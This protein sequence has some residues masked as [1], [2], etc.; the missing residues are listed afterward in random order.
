VGPLLASGLLLAGLGLR[1]VFL[2]AALPAAVCMLV[3]V[4]TVREAPRR[5]VEVAV[6]D[7]PR[8]P[9]GDSFG[10]YLAL[11]ALFTLGNSSDAFLLLRAQERGV[12][13]AA[14]PLLWSFHHVVKAAT[15]TWAGTLSDRIGRR[16]TIVAG[17]G[18]YAAAYAGFAFAPGPAAP[19]LL[20]AVYA[21]HHAATEGPERAFVADLA[22]SQARGRAFGVYHAVTGAMLLP[23]NLLTGWLWQAHGAAAALGLGAACALA[24]SLGLLTLVGEAR[25][26]SGSGVVSS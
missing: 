22:G 9:L 8:P 16:F 23:G 18:V 10:R 4:F 19:W 11:L 3:L 7:G 12:G 13:L 24:A 15:S 20:F 17:W 6:R 14:I 26:E 1:S 21:L 2:C 5:R 25:G